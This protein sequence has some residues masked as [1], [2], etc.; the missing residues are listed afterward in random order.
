MHQKRAKTVF[1]TILLAFTIVLLKLFYWQIVKG[2]EFRKKAILQSYKLEKVLPLKGIITSSDDYP[3]VLS[4]DSYQVSIYKPN[5]K[6]DINS[7][8][9]QVNQIVPGL[10]DTNHST[11]KSFISN[12]NIKW[13]DL[14][15]KISRNEMEKINLPGINFK[16]YQS[17]FYPENNLAKNILI[18][19]ENFYTKQL[20]GKTGYSLTAKDA[21]GNTLLTKKSWHKP[22]INGQGLNTYL[23]RGIQSQTELLLSEGIKQFSA[24]SGSI[25]IID[26]QTGGILAMSSQEAT[27]SASP[28]AS[29]N[30]SISD[31][32]EPGSIFKPLVVSMA[33]DKKVI[34]T[35]YI[36]TK[37]NQ[38]INFGE[39]IIENWDNQLHPNSNLKDIIKNSD[40]IGMS[41]I[42]ARLKL[43]NFLN[44]YSDLG[45]NQKTDIDL[46]GET[47]S[48]VKKYWSDVDLATASFGQGVA[49]TQIQ[50]L[51][52]FNTIANNG[53][54]VY[55]KVVKSITE[56]GKI[57]K[58]NQPKTKRVFQE[59]TIKEVK[60]ILKYAVENGAVAKLKPKQL[61][62]CAKSG[63]AQVAVKGGY[64][65]D[66]GIASYIGFSPCQNP[67]FTMIVTINNPKTSSW[68]SNTAAPIWFDLAGRIYN[69]L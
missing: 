66:S 42:I 8:I 17:R 6:S 56:N 58:L 38:A 12:Q 61:E 9:T 33:L 30:I 24:D 68:G 64:S 1:V 39:Y 13:I 28:S 41:H 54:L 52:A 57:I 50:M 11:I 51:Q 43:D 29:K 15:T 67:K 40:N 21:V 26:S 16:K 59:S 34:D 49:I 31:L 7:V 65:E 63:T 37:C 62:V 46:R 32:F 22:A 53:I 4:Q 23:H 27:Y 5:L 44:Y 18:G 25:I 36:C 35:N 10:I 69:L 48:T 3:L 14:P 19:L 45:L 20:A 47:K 60:S 2:D 55:P